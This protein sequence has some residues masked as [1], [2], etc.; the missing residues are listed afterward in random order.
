MKN[1]MVLKNGRDSSYPAFCGSL[2]G[3]TGQLLYPA[4]IGKIR[5]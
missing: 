1:G 5:W 3:G 2:R 4:L